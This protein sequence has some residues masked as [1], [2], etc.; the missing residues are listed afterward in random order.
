MMLAA[1]SL[2]LVAN[3]YDPPRTASPQTE[4]IAT[5]SVHIIAAEVIDFVTAGSQGSARQHRIREGMPLVEFY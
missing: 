4:R 2:A 1:L 3:S 5:A